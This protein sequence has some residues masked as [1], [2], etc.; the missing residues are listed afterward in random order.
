MVPLRN[1]LFLIKSKHAF[2]NYRN[3]DYFESKRNYSYSHQQPGGKEFVEVPQPYGVNNAYRYICTEVSRN[4]L[5]RTEQDRRRNRH[6][7][8]RE[9]LRTRVSIK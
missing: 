1:G 9:D 6:G 5:P 7:T 2:R 3:H 8:V 4:L